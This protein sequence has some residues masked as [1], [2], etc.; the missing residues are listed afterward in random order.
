VNMGRSN[1][2]DKD[3]LVATCRF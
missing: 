2:C 1:L 3:F